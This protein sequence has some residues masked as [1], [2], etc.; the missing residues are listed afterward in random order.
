MRK[1]VSMM[2]CGAVAG[3]QGANGCRAGACSPGSNPRS[4]GRA[5]LSCSACSGSGPSAICG[6]CRPDRCS[7]CLSCWFGKLEMDQARR[8]LCSS[9]MYSVLCRAC[10]WC[11]RHVWKSCI[12]ACY[13][14]LASLGLRPLA[15][16]Q[17][18]ACSR[19]TTLLKYTRYITIVLEAF[20]H[21][22][23]R[24]QR[25]WSARLVASTMQH[26]SSHRQHH[27]SCH[28]QCMPCSQ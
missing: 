21:P 2:A 13:S 18:A 23:K 6:T 17:A 22:S 28:H 15:K 8:S 5:I 27:T 7:A 10:Q 20:N 1:L 16:L 19:G 25:C 12:N 3:Q 4:G 26:L 14:I 9:W 24:A 11:V